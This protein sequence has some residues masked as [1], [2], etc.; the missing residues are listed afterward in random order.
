MLGQR[1]HRDIAAQPP[2]DH[3]EPGNDR[4]DRATQ[5]GQRALV[6]VD[7]AGRE[8]DHVGQCSHRRRPALVQ[9]LGEDEPH[10]D[11]A[12]PRQ[13]RP[14]SAQ[15]PRGPAV[16]DMHHDRCT[17]SIARGLGH[18][19]PDRNRSGTGGLRHDGVEFA[20]GGGS[21]QGGDQTRQDDQQPAPLCWGAGCCRGGRSPAG[22]TRAGGCPPHCLLRSQ[23][24]FR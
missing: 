15:I 17:I 19:D 6:P 3:A 2:P 7:A 12:L 10:F 9:R 22:T 5:V 11:E 8:G 13:R 23:S 24:N 20:D 4:P 14:E 18:G 21:R 16:G 1:H